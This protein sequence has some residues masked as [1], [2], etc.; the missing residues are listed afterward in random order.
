MKII[1]PLSYYLE[2]VWGK[3]KETFQSV[4]N[5]FNISEYLICLQKHTQMQMKQPIK[6]YS[7]EIGFS[8]YLNEFSGISNSL[9]TLGDAQVKIINQ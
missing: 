2:I 1:S 5:F 7:Y 3:H 9:E 8:H 4:D 6:F